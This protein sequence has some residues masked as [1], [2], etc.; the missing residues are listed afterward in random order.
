MAGRERGIAVWALILLLATIFPAAGGA[1]TIT[2]LNGDQLS[3]EILSRDAKTVVLKHP[4]L[5]ELKI[6]TAQISS[7]PTAPPPKTGRLEVPREEPAAKD[8]GPTADTTTTAKQ[9]TPDS[10]TTPTTT[11]TASTNTA[12][13]TTSKNEPGTTAGKISPKLPGLFGSG[14][15]EG[16]TRRISFGV[17]G[18][19]GN[20]VSLDATLSFETSFHNRAHRMAVTSAYYYES[21]DYKKN[22]SKGHLNI[23]RDWLLPESEWFYYAYFRYEFDYFKSWAHRISISGGSGYDFY[24]SDRLQLNGRVGLGVSR[25]FGND[26]KFDPE[27]QLGMEWKWQPKAFKNQ[28]ISTQFIIYPHLSNLGEYRTWIQGSWRIDFG[29]F[30]G[31]GLELGFE[32]EFETELDINDEDER[33]YDLIYYTRFGLDF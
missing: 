27:G 6:P 32:H 30:H 5:G 19:A 21:D 4:V 9:K 25:T 1:T 18:E 22:T 23:V 17:E 13:K 7:L 8:A 24:D 12:H 16:W 20:D 10:S 14:F 26:D 3:G 2:L 28:T 31:L 15:L 29:I 11:K 33:H